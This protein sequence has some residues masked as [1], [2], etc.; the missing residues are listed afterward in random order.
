MFIHLTKVTGT[1]ALMQA[2]L[3]PEEAQDILDCLRDGLMDAAEGAVKHLMEATTAVA[4]GTQEA[5]VE[6]N[7]R[8]KPAGGGA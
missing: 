5:V 6:F 4:A 8:N 2:T 3:S 7:A 1:E